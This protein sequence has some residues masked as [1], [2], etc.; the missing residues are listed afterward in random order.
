MSV[1]LGH[2][3]TAQ[4]RGHLILSR[5][6]AQQSK[7]LRGEKQEYLSDAWRA[8]GPI[9]SKLGIASG[10]SLRKGVQEMLSQSLQ[11]WGLPTSVSPSPAASG[12]LL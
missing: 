1:L 2:P 12:I 10:R 4:V 11:A 8:G 6:E 3:G 5:R 7:A 9:T